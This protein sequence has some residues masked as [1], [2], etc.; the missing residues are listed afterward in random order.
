MMQS[1]SRTIFFR[2]DPKTD[3]VGSFANPYGLM[4]EQGMK[5]GR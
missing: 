1:P 5:E 4:P 2:P 3:K